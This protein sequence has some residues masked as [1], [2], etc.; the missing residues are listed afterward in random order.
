M[1]NKHRLPYS[2]AGK[3]GYHITDFSGTQS[4]SSAFRC[5][6]IKYSLHVLYIFV[7]RIYH[8][9]RYGRRRNK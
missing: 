2:A 3:H 7:F 6:I 1:G 5:P 4:L 8:R 9:G